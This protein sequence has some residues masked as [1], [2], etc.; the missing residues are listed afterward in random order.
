[1]ITERRVVM[2]Q[3][4]LRKIAEL[5]HIPPSELIAV[6]ELR[7]DSPRYGGGFTIML[8]VADGA[9]CEAIT[10]IEADYS[11]ELLQCTIEER[12]HD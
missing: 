11:A 1:M 10:Q 9:L 2:H 7:L 8:K 3:E 5:L 4:H 12:Q 6:H